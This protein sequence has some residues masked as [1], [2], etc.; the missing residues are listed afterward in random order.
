MGQYLLPLSE[1]ASVTLDS[2]GNGLV[3]I[4]PTNTYQVWKPSSAAC[5]VSSQNSEPRFYLYNGRTVDQTRR[6][7]GTWTG[8]NDSTDLNGIVLYPGSV[9]TG[10]WIGGDPGATAT[11]SL[12]GDVER[13]P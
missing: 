12:N 6:I 13:Y 2:N 10:Q 3:F 7:G 9:L 11:L 1:G 4:G 5:V 8:S